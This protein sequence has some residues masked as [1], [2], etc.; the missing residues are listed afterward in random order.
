MLYKITHNKLYITHESDCIV[1][2]GWLRSDNFYDNVYYVLN[3]DDLETYKIN[4]YYRCSD[5]IKEL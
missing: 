1:K 3:I 5:D 2:E 4:I